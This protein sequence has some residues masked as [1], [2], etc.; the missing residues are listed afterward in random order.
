MKEIYDFHDNNDDDK[1][2]K[3]LQGLFTCVVLDY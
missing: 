3:N 2:I 1:V